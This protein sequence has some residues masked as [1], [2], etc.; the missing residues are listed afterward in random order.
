MRLS[1]RK[2]QKPSSTVAPLNST[3]YSTLFLDTSKP[4]EIPNKTPVSPAEVEDK[5][6]EPDEVPNLPENL[7]GFR[8]KEPKPPPSFQKSFDR[9]SSENFQRMRPTSWSPP[10]AQRKNLPQNRSSDPGTIEFIPPSQP[11]IESE[12]QASRISNFVGISTSKSENV[13]KITVSPLS[14]SPL[15]HRLQIGS[16]DAPSKGGRRTSIMINGDQ[17]LNSETSSDN[18]VTI[19]VGGE[20]S[21]CNP[22]VI[23]V[24]SDISPKIKSSSENRTLVILDNY[25]SNIIVE[26]SKL[27]SKR[28][29][30]SYSEGSDDSLERG[31][32]LSTIPSPEKREYVKSSSFEERSS[33]P[34]VKLRNTGNVDGV[35]GLSKEAVVSKL[36]E[37]SLKKAR[38]NGEIL[39]ETSGEAILKILKQTLLKSADYENSESTL[40]PEATYSRSSS[41]NS[42]VDF[43]AA[44]MYIEENPYEVIKEPIYEEIPDEPPPLPLSPPPSE[45]YAKDQI[46]FGEEYKEAYYKK[47]NS[48]HLLRSYFPEDFFKK[49]TPEELG[50]KKLSTQEENYASKF[51]LL[52]YLIDSKERTGLVEEEEDA[53]GELDA[54]YEQ[55]ETSLDDLSSKSSQISNVSDSSEE[56]N[57]ALATSSSPETLKVGFGSQ[58]LKNFV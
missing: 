6:T 38:R 30:R 16:S 58:S 19:S 15:V 56:S 8:E 48:G 42:E 20:D 26:P 10:P 2:R 14:E 52:N 33:S 43:V 34:E 36:L 21:V 55:K 51:E 57:I 32:S 9:S 53:E 12:T 41:L 3:D 17:N 44:N 23:S 4:V 46:Y 27:E 40:E 1:I 28:V 25:S 11:P 37:D 39:D 18:K 49:P 24:N 13:F 31:M 50:T 45:N 7:S 47:F 35:A 29:S 22:T 5:Q 54:L